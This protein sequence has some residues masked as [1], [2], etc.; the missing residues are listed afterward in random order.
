MT[1]APN[2]QVT[3]IIPTLAESDRR[4]SLLKAL[5]NVTHQAGIDAVPLVVINGDRFDPGLR[6]EIEN[7][8]GVE[9][10]YCSDAHVANAQAFGVEHVST[11]FFSFLDDDDLLTEDALSHR[12]TFMTP[13]IDV[14][15][16][17]IYIE[18]NGI[19]SLLTPDI[20]HFCKD[21]RNSIFELCWLNSANCLFRSETI[22]AVVFH[23]RS[24]YMEWTALAIRLSKSKKIA[25][26]NKATA[27]YFDTSQSASKKRAYIEAQATLMGT[28]RRHQYPPETRRLIDH[29][30]CAALN[31][32]SQMA[33][34]SGDTI[35][36]WKYHIKC[37]LVPTGW[38]YLAYTR[39]LF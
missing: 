27:I 5:D 7:M 17:N 22:S 15:V 36:A 24:P 39:K 1:P 13:G 8:K 28:L 20:T 11:P 33:S 29:K 10:I 3:V 31:S 14:V 25:F 16:T 32:L 26:S 30:R 21:P 18:K 37:L 2:Y 34:A 9:T 35:D 38:R 23:D 19:R 4:K 12:I 6:K